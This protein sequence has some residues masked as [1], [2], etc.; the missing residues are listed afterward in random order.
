MTRQKKVLITFAFAL[1]ASIGIA[2]PAV[3]DNHAAGGTEAAVLV[4]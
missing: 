1:A 4:K 3:A 2:S